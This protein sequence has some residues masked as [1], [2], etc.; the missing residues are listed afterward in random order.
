M[1]KPKRASPEDFTREVGTPK[2][3]VYFGVDWDEKTTTILNAIATDILSYQRI[4]PASGRLVVVCKDAAF[5]KRIGDALGVDVLDGA[6]FHKKCRVWKLYYIKARP[7]VPESADTCYEKQV[8][9][10][11]KR[12]LRMTQDD[13]RYPSLY[14]PGDNRVVPPGKSPNINK[15]PPHFHRGPPTGIFPGWNGL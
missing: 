3:L 4:V 14:N 1:S 2:E 15:I 13:S 12:V 9:K 11:Y 7:P 6:P 8:S 5:L 10:P